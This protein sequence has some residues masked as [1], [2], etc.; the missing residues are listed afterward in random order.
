MKLKDISSIT[1]KS[2][3]AVISAG[4]HDAGTPRP[5]VPLMDR[6]MGDATIAENVDALL[7]EKFGRRRPDPR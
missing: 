1:G 6:G 3:A 2:E 5:R 7:E 4:T